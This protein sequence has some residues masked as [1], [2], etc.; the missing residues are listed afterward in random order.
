MLFLDPAGTAAEAE[1]LEIEASC[2]PLRWVVV[3]NANL[4]GH[5][6][7]VREHLLGLGGEWAEVL[8]GRTSDPWG[9]GRPAWI[10]DLYRSRSWTVLARTRE[11]C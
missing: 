5:A 1:F 9:A 4:P 2:W 11:L 3:N 8:S 6:G 10:A 7:W